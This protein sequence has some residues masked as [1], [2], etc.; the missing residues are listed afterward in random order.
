MTSQIGNLDL[1]F[2]SLKY[3]MHSSRMS[4]HFVGSFV[5]TSYRGLKGSD[6]CDFGSGDGTS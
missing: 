4:C 2:V 1:L 5:S 6:P 3:I